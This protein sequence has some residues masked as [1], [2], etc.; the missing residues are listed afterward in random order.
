MQ[1]LIEIGIQVSFVDATDIKNIEKAYN[2][3]TRMVFTETIANPGT[4]IAQLEKIGEFCS[5]RNLIYIVDNTI[6]S[7]YLFKPVQ[8]K[9]SLVVNS[10]TKYI[11]G[12]GD[13]LGGSITDT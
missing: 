5:E 7:P 6:T 13:A 8:V 2:S 10:L 1:T 3:K 9:A 4:Q 11:G 12:H